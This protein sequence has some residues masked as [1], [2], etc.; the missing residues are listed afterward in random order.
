MS[1]IGGGR[2]DERRERIVSGNVWRTVWWLAVPAVFTML[3]QTLDGMID[4]FFVGRL[5]SD[6]LAAIGL[7]TQVMLFLMTIG[8]AVSI[9]ATALVA[10]FVGAREFDNAEI[11][12]RQSLLLA[13]ALSVVTGA[14]F[15]GLAPTIVGTLL[16]GSG[17]VLRLGVVYLNIQMLGIVPFFLS[18]VLA[19]VFRGMGDMRTPLIVMVVSTVIGF[20]SDYLLILGP[21]PFPR[22]GV[23]GASIS[24]DIS[25]VVSAAMFI[26]YLCRSPLYN[27]RRGPWRPS[28]SWFA[29]ILRIGVPAG[30][31]G[32]ARTLASWGYFNLLGLVPGAN[33]AQAALSVGL[34]IEALAYMPGVAFGAAATSM[35]GQNLGARMPERAERGAWAAA[36]QAVWVMGAVGLIFV[37]FGRPIAGFFTHDPSVL[38]FTALYLRINGVSEPFFAFAMVLTGALQGAGETRRPSIVTVA[39]LWFVRLP[40]TYYL[41]ITLRLAT[42]GAWIAMSASSILLGFATL[43][44]FKT[45]PWQSKEI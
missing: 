43:A 9:G 6:A 38:R 36:W 27:S 23:V 26:P 24:T 33:A 4:I 14:V 10:R 7:G 21:G 22:L 19:G 2:E 11:A 3:L 20:I 8:M 35:V 42:T 30:L 18:F 28:W 40:L 41:A 34:R 31:Q 12:I 45:I 15:Y 39:V 1:T 29:R 37:L 44:V 16:R 13:V 17:E 32:W 25:R 5:S